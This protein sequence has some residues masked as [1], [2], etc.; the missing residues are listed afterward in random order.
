MHDGKVTA[1]KITES[2]DCGLTENTYSVHT[3][4]L[5]LI[6]KFLNGITIIWDKNTRV[7]A[8]LDPRWH[9]RISLI[10]D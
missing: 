3:V 4:G 10:S 8:I 1:S 6:L 5:Y 2:K 7:S 9:V